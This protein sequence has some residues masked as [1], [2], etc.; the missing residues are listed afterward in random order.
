M[1]PI[2]R[3]LWQRSLFGPEPAHIVLRGPSILF[4]L[5]VADVIEALEAMPADSVHCVFFSPPYWLIRDY[6]VPGQWGQEAT[7]LEHVQNILRLFEAL[8]RVLHPTGVVWMNYQDVVAQNGRQATQEEIASNIKRMAEHEYQTQAYAHRKWQRAAQTARRSG[9]RPKNLIGI[10]GILAKAIQMAGWWWRGEVIWEK[11]NCNSESV[12]DRPSRSHEMLYMFTKRP[13]YFYNIYAVRNKQRQDEDGWIHGTQLRSVWRIPAKASKS[14]HPATFPLELPRRGV[15][16]GSSHLGCCPECLFPVVPIYEPGQPDLRAQ[17]ACG[18]NAQ[19][20]YNGK[21]K[22]DYAATG[23]QN[24]SD[25]KRNRLKSLRPWRLS[26]ERPSCRCLTKMDRAI[27]CTVLDPFSGEGTT[28]LAALQNGRA[29]RGIEL[30][31][32]HAQWQIDNVAPLA[33]Q[34]GTNSNG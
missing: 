23:Q 32:G 17:R 14:G 18:G 6:G 33:A 29:Y 3:P 12:K 5:W 9:L 4:E 22:R 25:V 1:T 19:G 16:L 20:E 31:P 2:S 24:P 13:K 28:G 10:P 30:H 11:S 34:I 27:P 26:G 7:L 15:L 8:K 21:G